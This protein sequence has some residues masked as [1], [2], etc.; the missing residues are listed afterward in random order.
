MIMQS[1]FLI[2]IFTTSG[3]GRQAA[4][5]SIVAGVK[6]PKTRLERTGHSTLFVDFV[7][8]G[9]AFMAWVQ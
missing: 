5:A 6:P 7:V 1:R 4:G 3:P 8:P 2:E 9:V